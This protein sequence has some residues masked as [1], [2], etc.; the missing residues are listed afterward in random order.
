M[1][2]IGVIYLM[3]IGGIQGVTMFK[4]VWIVV[5]LVLLFVLPLNAQDDWPEGC[6]VH[7]L[8]GVLH[9][10]EDAQTRGD[11]AGY[12][13]GLSDAKYYVDIAFYWC[14]HGEGNSRMDLHEANLAMADLQGANLTEANL[15]GAVL[16]GANLDNVALRNADLR[17]ALFHMPYCPKGTSLQG[18]D[19]QGADLS[20]SVL[21]YSNLRGANL[22]D[23]NLQGAIMRGADLS[24]AEL[25]GAMFG[26]D[27]LLPDGTYWTADTNIAR[28]TDPDNVD[29]W[30]SDEPES[31]AYRG[32]CES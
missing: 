19:L 17:G 18:A 6:D 16:C 5:A 15:E 20:E 28:F 31:P 27:T 11:L 29:F 1:P 4:R 26:V 8:E 22:S 10:I 12:V 3:R 25:N 13:R 23:S 30:R 7:E 32:S 2:S 9:S 24:H 21:A 14:L